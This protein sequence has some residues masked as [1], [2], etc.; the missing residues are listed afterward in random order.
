MYHATAANSPT[1]HSRLVRE[2]PKT[3]WI[4]LGADFVEN[5]LHT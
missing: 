5:G 2:D 1:M 4:G 3:H